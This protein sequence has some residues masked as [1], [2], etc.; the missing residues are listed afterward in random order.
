M[1]FKP[2]FLGR[3]G[4]NIQ[5]LSF[6]NKVKFLHHKKWVFYGGQEKKTAHNSGLPLH[7]SYSYNGLQQKR[8]RQFVRT[9]YNL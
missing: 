5:I 2:V 8:L 6:D 3:G 7:S 4:E 1:W 9:H